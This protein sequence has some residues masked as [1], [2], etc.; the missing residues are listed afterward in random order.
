MPWGPVR[1]ALS[2]GFRLGLFE[3][4]VESV[5]W[6][7]D[8]GGASAV[9]FRLGKGVRDAP[10]R[11]HGGSTATAELETHEIQ[12]L[13]DQI[14]ELRKVAAG[15]ALRIKVLIEFGETDTVDQELVDRVNAILEDVKEG[16]RIGTKE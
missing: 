8:L 10:A 15:H 14:D 9:K 16:W 5:P 4:T 3:R 7:C 2:D 13:A 1:Q 11:A 12:D 6:P